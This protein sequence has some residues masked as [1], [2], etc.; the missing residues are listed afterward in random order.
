MGQQWKPPHHETLFCAQGYL[1]HYIKKC[2]WAMFLRYIQNT[3]GIFCLQIC[4]YVYANMPKYGKIQ[5]LKYFTSWNSW[6]VL[7]I[8]SNVD[9]K[10]LIS[11]SLLTT[12]YFGLCCQHHHFLLKGT[13]VF[14]DC[15]LLTP[16]DQIIVKLQ[17]CVDLCLY[18]EGRLSVDQGFSHASCV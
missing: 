7:I 5:H 18:K 13:L 4:Q 15:S 10:C 17:K 11:P 3:S 14:S 8:S 6:A 9:T 1:K 16:I 2:L 12:P